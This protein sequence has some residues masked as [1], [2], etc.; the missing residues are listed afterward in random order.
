[1]N[2]TEFYLNLEAQK[3]AWEIKGDDYSKPGGIRAKVTVEPDSKQGIRARGGALAWWWEPYQ[4]DCCPITAVCYGLT[5]DYYEMYEWQEAADA[6]LLDYSLASAIA[7][8]ADDDLDADPAKRAA[9]L[10]AIG[11]TDNYNE[12]EDNNQ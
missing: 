1:M 7:A 6:I 12:R 11:L 2:E 4:L 3:L 8:A 9:L 10:A 5:G